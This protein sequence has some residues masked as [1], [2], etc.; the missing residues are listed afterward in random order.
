MVSKKLLG[1][2]IAAAFSSQAF[3]VVNLND[4]DDAGS[5]VAFAKEAF[6]TTG[7]VTGND[8]GTYYKVGGAANTVL[9]TKVVLGTGFIVGQKRYLRIDLTNGVFTTLSNLSST[10]TTVAN[11]GATAAGSLVQGGQNKDTYAILELTAAVANI[12]Q[13]DVE[14]INID[15]IAISSANSAGIGI[16][17]Y[18][19]LTAAVNQTAGTSLNSK[20]LTGVFSTGSALKVTNTT[21][22]LTADVAADFKKFTA[23]AVTGNIGSFDVAADTSLKLPSTAAVAALTDLIVPASSKVVFKGDFTVGAWAYP[24]GGTA[25]TLNTAKTE[26]VGVDLATAFGAGAQAV[27]VTLPGDKVINKGD[28]TVEVTY[29]ALTNAAFAPAKYSAAFGS[30]VYNGTTIQVPYLTTFAD[31]KQRLVL[32]NRGNVD[33][34][35]TIN[36][37]SEAGTTASAGSAATGTLAAGKTT[38]LQVSDVVTITGA[39]TRTAA[40]VNIRAVSGNIDAATT[41]VNV[42]DKSTDTVKLQ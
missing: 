11:A 18:E 2:A 12:T 16:A 36:F 41:S 19:T 24:F 42:S 38:V 34:P 8:N 14:T 21:A 7:T 35:Y 22:T 10:A 15:E 6:L 33:A 27:G 23:G 25:F 37:T 40:T 32:V 13:T 9:D 39:T 20:S 28:Y 31:Y 26:T 29:A 5:K 1:L 30:V 3:A 4:K 17:I